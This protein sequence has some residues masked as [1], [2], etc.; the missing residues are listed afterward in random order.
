MSAISNLPPDIQAQID[1]ASQAHDQQAHIYVG[2]KSYGKPM[3]SNNTTAQPPSKHTTSIFD[4]TGYFKP[5][6]NPYTGAG[7]FIGLGLGYGIYSMAKKESWLRL[8]GYCFGG[9]MF[10]VLV[11]TGTSKLV[12]AIT[13]KVAPDLMPQPEQLLN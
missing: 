6:L 3:L 10:G 4:S 1:L 8:A 11:G 12:S 7:A 13:G 9:A 2:A 5:K